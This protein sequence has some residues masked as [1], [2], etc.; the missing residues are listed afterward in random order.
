MR[1]LFVGYHKARLSCKICLRTLQLIYNHCTIWTL[2]SALPLLRLALCLLNWSQWKNRE[3]VSIKLTTIPCSSNASNNAGSNSKS[4][5]DLSGEIFF[6]A[7]LI[8]SLDTLISNGEELSKYVSN[9][10]V[11]WVILSKLL[12][13]ALYAQTSRCK[14]KIVMN[15]DL[16]MLER[17][18]H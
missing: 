10:R 1:N 12:S 16:R 14:S 2:T 3:Y 15:I 5:F 8:R 9:M 6:L 18:L 11:A 13:N 17:F 7:S 4:L